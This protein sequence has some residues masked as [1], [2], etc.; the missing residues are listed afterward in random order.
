MKQRC[1]DF[2]WHGGR[3]DWPHANMGKER[4]E[5]EVYIRRIRNREKQLYAE[6]YLAFL[7]GTE[8]HPHDIGLS[9]D[10]SWMAKQAVQIQLNEILKMK[11]QS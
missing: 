5:A 6:A 9:P 10:L 2:H 1:C 11:V 8:P 3:L 7:D 4:K